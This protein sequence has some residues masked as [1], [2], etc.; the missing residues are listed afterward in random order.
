MRKFLVLLAPALL[1]ISTLANAA[2][3]SVNITVNEDG[4]GLFTNSDGFSQ[5][6]T[7]TL[8]NDPG[9]GGLSNVLT[10][11][12]LNPPD[13]VA[14]D[15]LLREETGSSLDGSI[16]DVVRFNASN[17]TLVFYSDNIDGFDSLADTAGPPGSLYTNTI[18]I[19]EIGTEANNGAVYTPLAGQPGF[20]AGAA[21]PVTYTFISDGAGPNVTPEPSSLILL[22]TG[23]LGAVGAARR[24][25]FA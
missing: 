5:A 3:F 10:Y 20:V 13:L 4:T 11:S 16:L 22:G 1:S 17:G 15:V 8:M 21:G 19:D 18:T 23:L 2:A 6:L 9:P 12:L 14:G 7:G 24:R 25:M